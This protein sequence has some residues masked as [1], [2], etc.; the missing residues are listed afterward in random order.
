MKTTESSPNTG[1]SSCPCTVVILHETEEALCRAT[2]LCDRIMKQ[3]WTDVDIRLDHWAFHDLE[4]AEV[5]YRAATRAGRADLLVVAAEGKGIFPIQFLQWADLMLGLR[6]HHEGALVGL[7]DPG[8]GAAGRDGQLHRLAIKAGMDYLNHLPISPKCGI[9]DIQGWCAT[10][11]Q[12][13]TGTLNEIIRSDPSFN[14][15]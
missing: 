8:P 10:R 2:A 4:I 13:V 11:A 9:P 7:L 3:H 15:N 5:G 1:P 12:T 14:A 6:K